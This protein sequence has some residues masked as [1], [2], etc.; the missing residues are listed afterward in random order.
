MARVSKELNNIIE[1]FDE[2]DFITEEELIEL[3]IDA[4]FI[5]NLNENALYIIDER[6]IGSVIHSIESIILSVIFAIM[7]NCNTFVQIHLFMKKR[8]EWLNKH[9]KFENG[10][11]SISTVKRVIGFINPKELDRVN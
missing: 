5:N 4:K 10:L 3:N 2:A 6:I 1:M 9:I 11:P 7:A 8:F